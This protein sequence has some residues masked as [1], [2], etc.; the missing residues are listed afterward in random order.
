MNR[1]SQNIARS[2]NDGEAEPSPVFRAVLIYEN[3]TAGA[4]ARCCLER[5]ARASSKVLEERMWNFDALGIR[6]ARNGAASAARKADVVAVSA[7]GQ[8]DFPGAVRAWFDMWL[9][10]LEDENP[11]LLALFD[12]LATR[13]VASISAY[14]SC[15]AQRAGIEFFSAHRQVSL[16]P[17][18]RPKEE[19]IWPE[20]VERALLSWL[21]IRGR[22]KRSLVSSRK[23]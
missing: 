22:V 5:L 19:A 21:T 16:F 6:E 10:L 13:T 8:L 18:V 9:W 12:S 20:S 23:C 15:I 3:V 17:V 11:A 14:L 4:R 7:S 1:K 2:V